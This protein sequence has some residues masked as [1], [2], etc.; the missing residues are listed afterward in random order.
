ME[1][2]YLSYKNIERHVVCKRIRKK[3]RWCS[4]LGYYMSMYVLWFIVQLSSI[5]GN[6]WVFIYLKP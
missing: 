4:V 6:A 2:L 5:F 3:K 1:P